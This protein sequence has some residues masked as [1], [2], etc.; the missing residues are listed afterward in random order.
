MARPS[1]LFWN[2]C[3]GSGGVKT[4]VLFL[5]IIGPG[6]LRG[7]GPLG[8]LGAKRVVSG[9]LWHSFVAHGYT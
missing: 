1:R 3:D 6:A 4:F 7:I 2:F 5:W 8:V 9:T